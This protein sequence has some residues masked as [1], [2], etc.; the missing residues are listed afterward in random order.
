MSG[1]N[2]TED[3]GQMSGVNRGSQ[4]MSG[5]NRGQRTEFQGIFKM[6]WWDVFLTLVS[7]NPGNLPP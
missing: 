5:V 6:K 3:R 1:V 7:E 2:R 4:Q